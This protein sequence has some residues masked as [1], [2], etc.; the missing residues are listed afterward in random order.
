METKD[1]IC[2]DAFKKFAIRFNWF[3][4]GSKEDKSLVMPNMEIEGVTY[5]VNFCPSCGKKVRN[6]QTSEN[7][8]K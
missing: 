4:L 5:R 2:C 3:L 7:L 6:I 1:E 8:L